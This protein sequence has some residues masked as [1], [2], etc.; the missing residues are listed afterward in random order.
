MCFMKWRKQSQKHVLQ[1]SNFRSKSNKHSFYW[2]G[3]PNTVIEVLFTN[4][5][6][7]FTPSDV[8]KYIVRFVL[9]IQIIKN[10]EFFKMNWI[11]D[12]NHVPELKSSVTLVFYALLFLEALS[13]IFYH[14]WLG[15]VDL[16]IVDLSASWDE[17]I[18]FENPHFSWNSNNQIHVVPSP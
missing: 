17:R 7:C 15:S 2:K 3:F 1:V 5:R 9:Q 11:H 14:F 18:R 8:V 13:D 12:C 4:T 10:S 16:L 6:A